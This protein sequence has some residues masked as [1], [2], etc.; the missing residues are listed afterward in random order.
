MNEKDKTLE[1]DVAVTSRTRLARNFKDIPF[2]PVMNDV[3]AAETVHRTLDA[4]SKGEDA[5]KF[6]LLR[7]QSLSDI[8][9]QKLVED[10]VI[11]PALAKKKDGAA[12]VSDDGMS[13]MVGEED[14]LRI[15]AMTPGF[16]LGEVFEKANA[17]DDLIDGAA[18]YAFDDQWGYLTS[19]PT[20]TG[21]GLRASVMLHLPALTI[22]GQM[23]SIIHT[24]APIGLT[25]RGY[26][27]EGSEGSG[28]LYQLSNQVTLGKSEEDILAGVRRYAQKLIDAERA[29][30]RRMEEQDRVGLEDRI[31]RSY[32]AMRYMRRV[33]SKEFMRLWS[34]IR[35]GAAMGLLDIGLDAIDALVTEAQSAHIMDKEHMGSAE[36]DQKRADLCRE[37][38]KKNSQEK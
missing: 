3:W 12:L 24:T 30:R 20:N 6:R 35:M 36:R 37:F 22:S 9:R 23:Q 25:I 38:A 34:D 32:G 4:L 27:G 21:T 33:D 28:N 16:A 17:V 14:H 29:L 15:Q 5:L 19:C 2:P 31:W 8:E 13:I 1:R 7:M 10:H 18:E 26:Y 11:S